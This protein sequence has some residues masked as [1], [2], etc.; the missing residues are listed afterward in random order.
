[1]ANARKKGM[2]TRQRKSLAKKATGSI[3]V[4]AAATRDKDREFI[5]SW[6]DSHKVMVSFIAGLIRNGIIEQNYTASLQDDVRDSLDIGCRCFSEG[7]TTWRSLKGSAAVRILA[8]ILKNPDVPA[9]FRGEQRLALEKAIKGVLFALGVQRSTPIPSGHENSDFFRP[10]CTLISEHLET[11]QPPRLQGTT[12][13]TLDRDSDY[14]VLGDN[15]VELPFHNNVQLKLAGTKM[16]SATDWA[17]KD[18]EFFDRAV[19]ISEELG[20][21]TKLA[22][23][24]EKQLKTKNVFSEDFHFTESKGSTQNCPVSFANVDAIDAFVSSQDRLSMPLQ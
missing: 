9:W 23:P 18:A 2:Q 6:L 13:A 24:A 17:I 12:K 4:L 10:L 22:R 8:F 3:G 7:A 11:I 19:L 14:F 16:D 15:K 21:E 5:E 1:M 20:H